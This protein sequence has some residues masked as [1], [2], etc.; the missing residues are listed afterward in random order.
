MRSIAGFTVLALFSFGILNAATPVVHWSFDGV[1]TNSGSGGS[2]YDATLVNGPVYTN[3]T[4]GA[5]SLALDGVNDYVSA[6]YTLTDRG[7]IAM[8]YYAAPWYNYQSIYDNSV[9]GNDWRCGLM[10]V[11]D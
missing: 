5:A 9:G 3:G 8:W 2:A 10:S 6:P 1:S 11:A 7:S 4:I